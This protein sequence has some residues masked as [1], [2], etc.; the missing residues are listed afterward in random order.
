MSR[1]SSI[2]NHFSG[3]GKIPVEIEDVLALVKKFCPGEKIELKGVD[4]EPHPHRAF[5][6]AFVEPPLAG[7]ALMPIHCFHVNYS[8]RQ[9]IDWIR[10]VC[11]KELVHVLDPDPIQTKSKEQ[12][13]H[14]VGKLS[15]REQPKTTGANN[16]GHFADELAK[17]QALAILFP[18]AFYE[19]VYPLYVAEKIKPEEVAAKVG[20]PLEYVQT[21]L[22]D[23]WGHIH[24]TV[25]AY[26]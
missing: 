14:L 22:T 17:L 3:L 25:L 21:V 23:Q 18:Y 10:L 20:L 11:C 13:I 12:V 16:L 26:T 9:S 24:T 4:V 5:L 19:E 1:L 7:A 15:K 2:A 6:Y 8:T